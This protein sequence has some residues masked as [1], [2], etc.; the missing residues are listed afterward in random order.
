MMTHRKR[1]QMAQEGADRESLAQRGVELFEIAE[2]ARQ[3][4]ALRRHIRD[5][6][7]IGCWFPRRI[8]ATRCC[9]KRIDAA[10]GRVVY[11]AHTPQFFPFGPA[12]WNP[13]PAAAE[14]VARAAAVVA[15]GQH[16]AAV[17][18]A[19]HRTRSRGDSSAD[20]WQRTV[21]E[22]GVVRYGPGHHGQSVRGERHLDLRARWRSASLSTVS[23]RCP[24]GAPPPADRARACRVRE[25]RDAAELPPHRGVSA[26]A[27]ASC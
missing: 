22:S 3:P 20:L 9:A 14:L 5:F 16:T 2:R 13:D 23:V 6:S 1:T 18:T 19:A 7:R 27:H 8:W 25:H 4:A 17:H 21:S 15:I 26:A 11:L 12:S 10:P 24:D